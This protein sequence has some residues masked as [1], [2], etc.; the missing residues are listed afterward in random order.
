MIEI[1][2]HG[3]G[4]QGVK[5]TAQILG[6]AGYFEGYKTQDFAM[7]GAERRGAPVISFV[8]L[9]RNPIKTRG[10][11]FEPDY[12]IILDDTLDWKYTLKGRKKG[13]KIIVNTKK[14]IKM[15]NLYKIDATHIALKY[16]K[17]PITNVA[18]LGAFAKVSN[19]VS[20]KSILKA[21]RIELKKYGEDIIKK[22][23]TLAKEAFNKVK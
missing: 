3:R 8:R 2:I 20:I 16:F 14:G 9:D 23:I 19:L 10:Y 1:R 4:G 22:N 7:Y 6:R 11:I 12:I 15:S 5:K 13:T 18:M 21:V 17:R